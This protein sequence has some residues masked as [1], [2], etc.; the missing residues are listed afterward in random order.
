MNIQEIK[1]KQ[2]NIAKQLTSKEL[3][4]ALDALGELVKETHNSALI[5]AHYNI[6]IS[7]KSLLRYTVEGV[8]DPERQKI[9]HQIIADLF[10]LSDD[11]FFIL[12]STYSS[13]LL[14]EIRR[15]H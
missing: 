4:N 3:K 13:E 10:N 15:K 8:L 2:S 11:I 1:N 7:Y 12:Q 5:D 9:Y 6:E 14:Y